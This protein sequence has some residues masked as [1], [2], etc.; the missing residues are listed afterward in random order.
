MTL[1]E[2]A[3]LADEYETVNVSSDIIKVLLNAY[4]MAQEYQ[5]WLDKT[6]AGAF[7]VNDD[8]AE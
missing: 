6:Q 7:P 2:L 4:E 1:E 3:M 5:W 8:I